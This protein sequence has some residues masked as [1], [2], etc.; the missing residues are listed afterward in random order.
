MPLCL[1]GKKASGEAYIEQRQPVLQGLQGEAAKDES[2]AEGSESPLG[3]VVRIIF[4]VGSHGYA[5]TGDKAGYEPYPE[6][7][8]PGVLKPVH[9]SATSKCR[10]NVAYSANHRSPKLTTRQARPAKG[11]IVNSGAH[12]ARI[13]E[14]LAGRD[15]RGKRDCVFEAETPVEPSGET[16]SADGAEKSFPKQRVMVQSASGSTEFN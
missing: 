5:D 7:K 12:S 3:K 11:C 2:D 6:R 16:Q 13:G 4:D 8:D 14:Y 1:C 10:G 9:Q 15:E